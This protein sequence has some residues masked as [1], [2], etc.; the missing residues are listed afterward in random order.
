LAALQ[1]AASWFRE[2]T[3]EGEATLT[4]GLGVANRWASARR[5]DHRQ[6]DGTP[7]NP[8]S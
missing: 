3:P 6:T 5:V 8:A 7:K 2:E 4:P 1:S